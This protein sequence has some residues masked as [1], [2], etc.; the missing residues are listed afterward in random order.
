MKSQHLLFML[1]L[2][3]VFIQCKS[4]QKATVSDESDIYMIG[5]DKTAPINHNSDIGIDWETEKPV[6]EFTLEGKNKLTYKF[7]LLNDSTAVLSQQVDNNWQQQD[8]FEFQP[9]LWMVTEEGVASRFEIK[10][11]NQDGN[12]DLVCLVASNVNTNEWV[13]IYLND[14]KKLVKLYNTADSSYIWDNPQYD[15]KRKTINTELFS[16]AYG[17]ANTAI[18]KL[19]GVLATPIEKN[20][21]DSATHADA[22]IHNNYI[23]ENGKWKLIKTETE[24]IG[25]E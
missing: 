9:W 10:D 23:G 15:S 14:G 16:S 13:Y 8:K 25:E 12:E 7:E 5:F 3:L 17:I 19:E 18:Y 6:A 24:K 11:F 21:G 1:V 2:C 20:E 4:H 22:I